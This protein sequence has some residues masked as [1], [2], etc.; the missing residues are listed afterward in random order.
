MALDTTQ[1]SSRVFRT[2]SQ[3]ATEYVNDFSGGE[4]S[5]RAPTLLNPNQCQNLINVLV[6]DNFEAR[7]R[8]GADALPA[9]STHPIAN[10]ASILSLRYFDTPSYKQ[11]LASVNAGSAKFLKYEANAWTDLSNLWS[12]AAAD[13]RLAM[14][15]GIDKVLIADGSAGQIYDGAAFTATGANGNLNFPNQATIVSWFT[16][17]MFA[18]GV[19]NSPDTIWLSNFLDY[20]AG[21]WNGTTRSFRV[22][23]GDGD[24]IVSLAPMQGNT[25]AVLKRNSIWLL[26]CNPA[27]DNGVNTVATFAAQEALSYG[28][29]CV[30]RD[31]WCAY[32]NDIFFM[33]QDGVRSVQRMQAASG[34][35]QLT[36]PISQP[37]Q[38]YISRIN[39]SAWDKIVAIKYQELA[40][41]FVPLDN[42]L[43]NNYVLVYNG[44]LQTWIGKWIGWNG[45]CVE[46][47]RFNGTQHFVFGDMAGYVNQWKDLSSATDDTTYL[48]NGVSYPTKVWTRSFQFGESINNKTSHSTA[49]RFSAGN[50]PMSLSWFGDTTLAAN[51]SSTFPQSGDILGQDVLPFLLASNSPILVKKGIRGLPS[52]N[53]GYLAIESSSGW[54]WLKNI[55]VTAFV[56]PL[57]EV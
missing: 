30:G 11:L 29:G 35:W 42:S 48:D 10:A 14:A 44:R 23:K 34:Q 21:N 33:A 24:P 9:A 32:G 16:Q 15:Q 17:R 27:M 12:P 25:M 49:L 6:R 45:S 41:F 2:R 38:P 4:D 18:A 31:A 57:R 40:F 55:S 47:T 1:Y 37:I 56:N 50:A 8:P 28:I 39:Q 43:T 13:A 54:F 26:S 52:F 46:V 7:T 53:E 20:S 51:W 19:S 3:D 5:F 22:G 36:A